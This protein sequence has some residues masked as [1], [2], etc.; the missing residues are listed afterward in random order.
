M[1]VNNPHHTELLNIH[2]LSVMEKKS[3]IIPAA[4]TDNSECDNNSHGWGAPENITYTNFIH[5]QF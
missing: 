4:K 1:N 2:A 3:E 5:T